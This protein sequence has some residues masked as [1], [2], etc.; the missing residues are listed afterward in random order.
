M[1]LP[2]GTLPLIFT[3]IGMILVGS[4]LILFPREITIPSGSVRYGG[5]GDL[6]TFT[7][8]Q[9]QIFGSVFLLLGLFIG[10]RLKIG[11]LAKT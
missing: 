6:M 4:T 8:S 3:S 2:A 1:K 9:T 11:H 10:K 7:S 5:A